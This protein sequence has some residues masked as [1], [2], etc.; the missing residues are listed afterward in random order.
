MPKRLPPWLPTAWTVLVAL[1]AAVLLAG[2][3][4]PGRA[5]TTGSSLGAAELLARSRALER[6]WQ[7]VVG[8]QTVAVEDARSGPNL[9]QMR[10]G[11]G[12]VIGHD[13]LVLTV[14]YLVLEAESVT[15]HLGSGRVV[16]ARVVAQDAATGLGLVQAL[17]PLDIPPVPLGVAPLTTRDG[18]LTLVGGGAAAEVS[19]ARLLDHR[20]FSGTWEYHLERALITAPARQDHSGAALFNAQGELVGVGALFL[21]DAHAATATTP[22]RGGTREPG[23]LFVPA[24]LLPPILDELRRDGRSRASAR[25][26]LGLQCVEHEGDVRVLRV[27]DDSPADVAGL[28]HADQITAIDGLPVRSL[29]GL[30]QALWAGGPAERAVRLD[31]RR[32]DQPLQVTVHAVDRQK[33]LRRSQGI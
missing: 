24:D 25:A 6:A 27:N 5:Q 29:A 13:G 1:L 17:A 14:G 21:A 32:D 30:W 19:A 10:Q 31:I 22:R 7:A 18:P 16:P 2:W 11:S 33:T 20:P 12:V 15:L 8:V 9:G 4:S 26:W 28:Q 23:N 3:P